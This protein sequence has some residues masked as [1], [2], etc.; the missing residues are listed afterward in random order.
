MPPS[1]TTEKRG[2]AGSSSSAMLIAFVKM[3]T[4]RRSSRA[5]SAA[6]D[7]CGRRSDIQDHRLAVADELRGGASDARLLG[8]LGGTHLFER[9]L[10]SL[11]PRRHGT[12][13]N[14]HHPPIL[15]ERVQVAADRD[16]GDAEHLS[17]LGDAEELALAQS[18]EHALPCNSAG[19]RV[20][21]AVAG[22]HPRRR[23]VR[24]EVL[25]LHGRF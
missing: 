10:T 19:D 14:A 4:S 6:G 23:A 20:P 24:L 11:G 12:A 3:P 7:S 9:A 18:C 15:G 13:A 17:E 5:I 22:G 2:I 25:C 16:L 21:L 8:G 1:T